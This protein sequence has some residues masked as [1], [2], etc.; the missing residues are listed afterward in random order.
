[1][2]DVWGALAQ[3]APAATTLTDAYTVPAGKVATI[4]VIACNRGSA[5]SVR[6]AHA[7]GG[8]A[9]ANKQYVLYDYALADNDAITTKAITASATDVIRLYS[10][11]GD[12]SFTINGIEEDA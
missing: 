3:S 12:V 11:S 10:A 7:V 8:E 1:M 5:S 4:E 9:N 6:V 2:A